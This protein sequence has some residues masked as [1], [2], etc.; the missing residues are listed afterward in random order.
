VIDVGALP[1]NAEGHREIRGEV[2]S[3]L[4]NPFGANLNGEGVYVIDCLG[5]HVVIADSRIVATLVLVNPASGSSVENAVN[6]EPAVANYPALLVD[7][8][9]MLE[10]DDAALSE[11][12]VQVN[13]NPAGT[14]YLGSEDGDKKDEYPSLIKGLVYVSGDLTVHQTPTIEG[15]L[16]VGNTLLASGQAGSAVLTLTYQQAFLDNPPPGFGTLRMV[17]VPGSFRQVV[18]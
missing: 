3:P 7:G 18:D 15:V 17:V 5:Q 13:F 1:L 2:L 8:S 16:V 12:A 10:F 14:P 11:A 6:W 9:M 4:S